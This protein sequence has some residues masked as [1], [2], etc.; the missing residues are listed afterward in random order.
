MANT[1][2]SNLIETRRYDALPRQAVVMNQEYSYCAVG[3]LLWHSHIVRYWRLYPVACEDGETIELGDW[4]YPKVIVEGREETL[5]KE[6]KCFF[7]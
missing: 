5:L 6:Q 1:Y 4:E 7:R 2:I 3:K